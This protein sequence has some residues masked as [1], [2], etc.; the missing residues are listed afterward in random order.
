MT[1]L[2]DIWQKSP[3][4]LY[5]IPRSAQIRSSQGTPVFVGP[6]DRFTHLQ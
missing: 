5:N 2:S 4:F 3:L 1:L 6:V